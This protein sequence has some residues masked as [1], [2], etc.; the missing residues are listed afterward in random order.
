[1]Y[2]DLSGRFVNLTPGTLVYF[3]KCGKLYRNEEE[4]SGFHLMPM[5]LY[6]PR[7][8]VLLR[9]AFWVSIFLSMTSPLVLHGQGL[10]APGP[11]DNP[12][13][14]GQSDS[15]SGLS[16][17]RSFG[18]DARE[19]RENRVPAMQKE[20]TDASGVNWTQFFK[21][22][23]ETGARFSAPRLFMGN[24]QGQM[25][26]GSLFHAGSIGSG[27]FEDSFNVSSRGVNFSTKSSGLDLHLS[28][29]SM[30]RDGLSQTGAGSSF[31]GQGLNG[32][33]EGGFGSPGG[34]GTPGGGRDAQK[35]SGA[36]I[37][38]QLKF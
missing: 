10:T 24:G 29:N 38:L 20:F 33:P 6:R 34:F 28:V 14:T 30:F 23:V 37:A 18:S 7:G 2:R 21:S 1:V 8:G 32:T 26:G 3:F 19:K 25:G 15:P 16:S 4:S 36:K 12:F 5:T 22:A 13:P 17:G 9:L 35:G 11:A 27:A 31:A